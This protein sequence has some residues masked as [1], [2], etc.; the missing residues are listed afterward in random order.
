[1]GVVVWIGVD[2]FLGA[3]V[4][5]EPPPHRLPAMGPFPRA[6]ALLV[7]GTDGIGADPVQSGGARLGRWSRSRVRGESGLMV[8]P[9]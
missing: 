4:G 9:R 7:G 1:M 2:C 5:S 8:K 3:V 6:L